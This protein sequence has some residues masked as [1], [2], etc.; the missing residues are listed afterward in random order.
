[1]YNSLKNYILQYT[2][3]KYPEWIPKGEIDRRAINEWGFLTENCGRRC[4]ELVREGKLEVK[5]EKGKG[6]A[7]C[8]WYRYILPEPPKEGLVREMELAKLGVFG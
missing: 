3:S 5:L 1:M 6:G 8:A 7:R 4:R 2:R